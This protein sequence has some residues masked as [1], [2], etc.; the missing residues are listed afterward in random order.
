[1][2]I[3]TEAVLNF[4]DLGQGQPNWCLMTA[5]IVSPWLTV[6]EHGTSS[7]K[8]KFLFQLWNKMFRKRRDHMT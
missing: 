4:T 5:E 3:Y 6:L 1:M 2:A 7:S 8:C